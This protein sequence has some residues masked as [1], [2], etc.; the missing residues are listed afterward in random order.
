MN[1]VK[2]Q[3]M[4]EGKVRYLSNN[5]PTLKMVI[6]ETQFNF[7]EIARL[8]ILLERLVYGEEILAARQIAVAEILHGKTLNM[9]AGLKVEEES[10]KDG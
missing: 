1:L 10:Q 8:S 6:G 4:L 5:D 7:V 2:I 3:P 9:L